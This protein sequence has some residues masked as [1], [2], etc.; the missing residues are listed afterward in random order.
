MINLSFIIVNLLSATVVSADEIKI[1]LRAHEG[2]QRGLDLWQ[3]TADYLTEQIPEH[4]FT[5]VPF[6]NISAL[7]QAVSQ[8]KFDFILTNPSSFIKHQNLYG[9]QA[10]ATLLNKRQGK[11][12]S[13]FGSVIFTRAD[14]EDINEY[15]DLKG[16]SFI[17]VDELAFGGWRVAWEELLKNNINPYKDF[18]IMSFAGGIQQDVV[19]A[20]RDGL[21]D[22][23][24]VRTDMLERMQITKKIKLENYKVIGQKK[25]SE[26]PFLH[27]TALYPEWAFATGRDVSDQLK[28]RVVSALFS[29]QR[30]SRAAIS[31]R[32]IGWI[33]PMD[34]SPVDELLKSLH[35]GPYDVAIMGPFDRLKSQY[36]L[37]VSIILVVFITLLLL[38]FYMRVLVKRTRK[39]QQSLKDELVSREILERQLMHIQ[40]MESLGQLTGGIA[41]DFN[42]MLASI[43]G[44][45]ELSLNTETI[46]KDKTISKYLQQVLTAG[47]KAKLLV[48]QML[49][50]SRTEGDMDRTETMQVSSLIDDAQKLLR[51]LLPSNIEFKIINKGKNIYIKVNRVM[52]DQVLMNLCLNAKDA[53]TGSAGSGSITITT[54]LVDFDL[55]RCSSCYQDISGSY[56]V[57]EI[58][59]NGCGMDS[60]TKRRIFEPFFSTKDVG[61]GTGMGLSMVH[62]IVHEHGGHVLLETAINKGTD[63]KI[64]LPEASG[65][66]KTQHLHKAVV[67]TT[68]T[69]P[70]AEKHILILDDE[71]SI[72]TYLTEMLR[73]EGYQITAI[74]NSFEA[75]EFF[76]ENYKNIDLVIT[77]QTMPGLTGIELSLKMKAIK[78]DIAIVICT[79]YSE[80]LNTSVAK[81]MKLTALLDKPIEKV[82]LLETIESV[83]C[84]K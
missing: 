61:S 68:N 83:F 71:V 8:K 9:A 16:K 5:M 3:P 46:R 75:L 67:D 82:K 65:I 55:I 21:A 63:V 24:V 10:L 7:N 69:N 44:Y 27:S 26:F 77:D 28:T 32:Y 33:T 72:T 84:D 25:N 76:E 50:F 45:T 23:G 60:V 51:P 1:A 57:I 30:D 6:D 74:N 78:N 38:V 20:V 47:D 70:S 36:A 79:G 17:G 58:I 49:A 48:N 18:S 22:A 54:E 59:D 39:A 40:K 37:P 4:T 35:V 12:Y 43:L 13:K 2:F 41:H 14:R 11:G 34:Y 56:V 19:F 42:N 53:M 66:H 52:I 81:D 80:Y 31:G 73:R 15:K 29:I 64:L 62:G